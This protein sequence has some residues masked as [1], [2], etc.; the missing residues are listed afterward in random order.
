MPEQHFSLEELLKQMG[1]NTEK[2]GQVPRHKLPQIVQDILN[3][4]D[5]LQ[6]IGK[7]KD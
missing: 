3:L 4:N 2:P 6:A 1:L 5:R 7:K